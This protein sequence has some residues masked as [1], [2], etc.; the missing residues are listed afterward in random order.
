MAGHKYPSVSRAKRKLYPAYNPPA[1]EDVENAVIASLLRGEDLEEIF[2]ELDP[3]C[4]LES[5]PRPEIFREA[6]ELYGLTGSVSLDI[7]AQKIGT[8]GATL[9]DTYAS[10]GRPDLLEYF[11]KILV[12]Y[13]LRRAAAREAF[14][15]LISALDDTFLDDLIDQ[16]RT[17]LDRLPEQFREVGEKQERRSAVDDWYVF[18][19]DP[20]RRY[21]VLPGKDDLP[22][23]CRV[24]GRNV[25]EYTMFRNGF[26]RVTEK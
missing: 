17:F 12:Q 26:E 9:L 2:S 22:D 5:S 18:P 23:Y 20:K 14:K 24:D 8:D 6:K 1:A 19:G 13:K 25:S 3:D 7:L 21:K 11:I 16:C 15:I 10:V 4:F